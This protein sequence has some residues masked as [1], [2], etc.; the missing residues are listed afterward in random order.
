M[1][2]RGEIRQA[3]AAAAGQLVAERGSFTG[4]DVAHAA[5]VAFE[6]AR[7][8]LKDMVRA[9]ELVVVGETTAPGVCRPLNVYTQR[10]AQ[11]GHAGADLCQVVQRWAD[12][13]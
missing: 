3:V 10:A 12:F 6:K 5:Q 7:L 9:G 8:T 1:R 13:R 11:Q 2:P 4:R